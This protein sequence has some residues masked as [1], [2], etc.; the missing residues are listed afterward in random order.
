MRLHRFSAAGSHI[1]WVE[2]AAE[3]VA[4]YLAMPGYTD[5][6]PAASIPHGLGAIMGPSGW[7]TA[8]DQRGRAWIGPLGEVFVATE[9]G[10]T[11]PA[12]WTPMGFSSIGG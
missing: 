1:G 11:G 4:D 3:H 9:V 10:Q 12:G 5:I 6:P 8:P 7:A 2:V